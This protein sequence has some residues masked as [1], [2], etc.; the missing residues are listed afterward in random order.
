MLLPYPNCAI[1]TAVQFIRYSDHASNHLMVICSYSWYMAKMC[2]LWDGRAAE[3]RVFRLGRAL[4]RSRFAKGLGVPRDPRA[5]VRG[6]A[7]VATFIHFILHSSLPPCALNAS[8]PLRTHTAAMKRGATRQ[9]TRDDDRDDD[10]GR[11]DDVRF[12][13]SRVCPGVQY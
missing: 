3:H 6:E 13:P 11:G 5:S 12:L 1:F 2:A 8:S 9:L 7:G 10:D 4:C